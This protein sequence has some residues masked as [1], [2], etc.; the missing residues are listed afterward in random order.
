MEYVTACYRQKEEIAG[1]YLSLQQR[2]YRKSGRNAVSACISDDRDIV[3]HLQD[4]M[5]EELAGK[6]LW[7]PGREETL[8]ERWTEELSVFGADC[9]YAG[10]LC[11]EERVILFSHGRMQNF[12]FFRRFGKVGWKIL[13]AQCLV[14]EVEPGTAILAA[15]NAFINLS[16]EELAECLKPQITE[17]ISAEACERRAEK[18]LKELGEKAVT[19]GGRHMGAVWILPVSGGSLWREG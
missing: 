3:R 10:I 19:Q 5:D 17:N 6:T 8:R 18:R 15:D 14:G 13:D 1:L 11:A 9:N 12:A 2:R 4:K 7:Q 16:E